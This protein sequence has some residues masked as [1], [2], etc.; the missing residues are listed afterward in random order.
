MIYEYSKSYG[1]AD[2]ELDDAYSDRGR[3]RDDA[4]SEVDLMLSNARLQP[5][6]DLSE[7]CASAQPRI[8]SS[9]PRGSAMSSFLSEHI[10]YSLVL[11][12]FNEELVLLA[13]MG[14]RQAAVTFDRPGRKLT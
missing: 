7:F 9:K 5:M 8:R 14:F 12:V 13:W 10:A 6:A 11:P 3:S 1:L 2:E 4:G